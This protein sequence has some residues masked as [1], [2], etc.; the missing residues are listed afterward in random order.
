MKL[1]GKK[2]TIN[3][4]RLENNRAVMRVVKIHL[5]LKTFWHVRSRSKGSI[6]HLTG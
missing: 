2:E 1:S 6:P 3:L 5:W 4:I